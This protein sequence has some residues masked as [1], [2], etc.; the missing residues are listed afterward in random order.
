MKS[1]TNWLAMASAVFCGGLAAL[2][3]YDAWIAHNV[4]KIELP[5]LPQI[6]SRLAPSPTAVAA[7]EAAVR[8]QRRDSPQGRDLERRCIEYGEAARNTASQFAREER[9]TICAAWRHYLDTGRTR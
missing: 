3:T 7:Q 4:G 8:R 9:D 2:L 5:E 1:F 6:E